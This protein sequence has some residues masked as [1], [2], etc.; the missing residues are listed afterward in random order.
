MPFYDYECSK[1]GNVYEDSER[2]KKLFNCQIIN[3]GKTI[4]RKLNQYSIVSGF[5]Y[6]FF[7]FIVFVLLVLIL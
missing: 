5:Q 2:T 4:P 7:P 1:C 3:G 6:S